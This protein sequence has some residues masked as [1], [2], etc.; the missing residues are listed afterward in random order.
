[1]T[2]LRS[3]SL[4]EGAAIARLRSWIVR[5]GAAGS[6]QALFA[7][8]NFLLNV[9][10]ARSLPPAEY[11]AFALV[12]TLLILLMG[13]YNAFILE[14]STVIEP[15][16]YESHLGRYVRAQLGLHLAFTI[17][18]G[19]TLVVTGLFVG[20][21]TVTGGGSP[22]AAG[23]ALIAAGLSVPAIYL[24]WLARRF[25]YVLT[26]PFAALTGSAVYAACIGAGLVLGAWL[27][28]LTPLAGFVIM[29][30]ASLVAG[31]VMLARVARLT[32]ATTTASHPAFT[33]WSLAME[34]WQYGR[35]LLATVCLEAAVAP[36]I[37]FIATATLGLAAVGTLRAMQ[38]FVAPLGH[39]MSALSSL[40][41]PE[42]ARDFGSD[43][44]AAL[45][46]KHQA[47]IALLLFVGVGIELV[48]LFGHE[49]IERLFY[50]GK[51]ASASILIPVFGLAAV[52]E[53]LAA[54]YTMVLSAVRRPRLLLVGSAISAPAG[55][56]I[57]IV[58]IHMWGLN[59]AALAF[60]LNAAV[61]TIV[62]RRLARPWLSSDPRVM[63]LE[64]MVE[65]EESRAAS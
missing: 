29:G 8:G 24:F 50:A 39:G 53:S 32:P 41:L 28:L 14:P 19:A 45:Q 7:A 12:S 54:S 40:A 2:V 55:L 10:L 57:S 36:A 30:C 15:A 47:M 20:G 38:T 1:M 48:F 34:R 58:S 33:T 35:W 59:G 63:T 21:P 62:R 56:A 9:A 25:M 13:V 65:S 11:G 49:P 43:R 60:T 3:L 6:E 18:L 22:S 37:T 31:L 4:T 17:G 5:G 52:F 27:H 42:L 46:K 51:Y 26:R 64:R 23:G 61:S 16:R 44:H